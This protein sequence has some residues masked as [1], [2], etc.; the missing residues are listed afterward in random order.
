MS[1]SVGIVGL[2]NVGKST[3]FKAVTKNA[4]DIA[5]Y[6]FCTIEPNVGVVEVPDERLKKLVETSKSQKVVPTIIKFVDIAGLVKNAHEGAGLG[7]QFLAHIR[8]TDAIAEVV[9]VFRDDNVIHV[10]GVVEPAR[11]I[12]IINLELIFADLETA[13][14]RLEKLKKD[15]KGGA[16]KD[17]E[18]FIALLAKAKNWLED[19]RLLNT[20][21]LAEE[22]TKTL[23]ELNLL[24]I[25]PIFYIANVSEEQIKNFDR[26]SLG[27]DQALVIP[28]SAK[29]ESEL[30]ELE[31]N[32]RQEYLKELGLKK[33][34]L[35]EVIQLSYKILNL[36]TFFTSGEK[37]TRAWTITK[38]D[39]APQAAGK[40][41]SDFERGFICAETCGYEQFVE[42][43]GEAGVKEKGLMRQ[44]GKDYTV[45]DGDV[46]VFKFN[47]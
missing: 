3:L 29:I 40:I 36:I 37:E 35:D 28:I 1:L 45:K 27:V 25:K 20:L 5:N 6:P 19:G 2:P 39:K 10:E 41:H 9:R 8:E 42:S 16:T 11:D 47:V 38:G 44:E 24:T 22:E 23:K 7:N 33:S 12:E 31:E 46:M 14:K 18:K 17:S 34:G 13:G 32:E 4:V 43:G 21:N 26:N 15:S 30:A